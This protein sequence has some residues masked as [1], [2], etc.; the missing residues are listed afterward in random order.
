MDANEELWDDTESVRPGGK[1]A[2]SR[3]AVMFAVMKA[4][5]DDQWQG[6]IQICL[7]DAAVAMQELIRILKRMQD[8]KASDKPFS[9]SVMCKDCDGDV[10]P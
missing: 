3:A 10:Y 5:E 7:K 9:C 8:F 6:M 4:Y 2:L 1:G